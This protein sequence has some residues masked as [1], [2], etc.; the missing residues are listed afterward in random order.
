MEDL[1]LEEWCSQSLEELQ[2]MNMISQIEHRSEQKI[3]ELTKLLNQK[4]NTKHI[5]YVAI[6]SGGLVAI[7]TVI[8]AAI[9]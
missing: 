8:G 4:D 3:I 9:K 6:I 7:A 2:K 5:I 1:D